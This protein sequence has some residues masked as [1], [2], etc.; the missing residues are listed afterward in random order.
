MTL[1][2]DICR[3]NGWRD[4]TNQLVR[5]CATCRRVLE[6]QPSSERTPWFSTSPPLNGDDCQ[7]VV[8]TH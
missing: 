6:Q 5:P 4:E 1:A 2:Y 3:C 7:Y 8:H